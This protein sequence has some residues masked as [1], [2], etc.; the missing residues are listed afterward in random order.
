MSPPSYPETI[1]VSYLPHARPLSTHRGHVPCVSWT[2]A[3]AR[4]RPLPRAKCAAATSRPLHP[5]LSPTRR[6][7]VTSLSHN[8]STYTIPYPLPMHRLRHFRSY[9]ICLRTSYEITG[10]ETVYHAMLGGTDAA[11]GARL[12]GTDE[13]YGAIPYLVLTKRMVLR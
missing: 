9:A 13:A 5:T 7:Q 1:C 10:T 2:A 11:Y 6:S 8:P 3:A 4:S 12:G